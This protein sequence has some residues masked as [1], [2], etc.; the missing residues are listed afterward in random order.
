M[1]SSTL[2]LTSALEGVGVQRHAPAALPP[3]KTRYPLY[4]RLGGSQCRSERVR[5]ISPPPGFDTRT[6]QPVASRYTD[7]AIPAHVCFY[8]AI[9]MHVTLTSPSHDRNMFEPQRA[10][11]LNGWPTL[12]RSKNSLPFTAPKQQLASSELPMAGTS[13]GP[14]GSRSETS[15][16][17]WQTLLYGYRHVRSVTYTHRWWSDTGQIKTDHTWGSRT[18][19]L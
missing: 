15:T 6:V 19:R 13:P 7:W 5:K 11:Y 2:S 3:G 14:P 4:R 12:S 8:D 1:Y 17:V 9:K 10:E 16:G 18:A